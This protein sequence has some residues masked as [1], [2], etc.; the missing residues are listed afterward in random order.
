MRRLLSIGAPVV[1]LCYGDPGVMLGAIHVSQTCVR[2]QGSPMN[3]NN[4]S[5]GKVSDWNRFVFRHFK[6]KDSAVP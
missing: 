2:S 1:E 5:A 4:A 6:A 3:A